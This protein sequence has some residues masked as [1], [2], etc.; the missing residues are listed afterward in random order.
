MSNA[1]LLPSA[2]ADDVISKLSM[3]DDGDEVRVTT[4]TGLQ[5]EGVVE[6]Q[7]ANLDDRVKSN[8]KVYLQVVIAEDVAE[9]LGSVW[10]DIRLAAHRRQS[11][12]WTDLTAKIATA[13]N[14]NGESTEFE[15]LGEVEQI[16]RID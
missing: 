5:V 11:G 10:C 3:L 4:S 12:E 1:V 2:V 14:E 15:S 16:E 9:E 7:Y 6:A 13:V 8:R